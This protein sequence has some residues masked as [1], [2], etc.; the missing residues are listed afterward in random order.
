MKKIKKYKDIIAVFW[1][2]LIVSLI[3]NILIV[4][5]YLGDELW[6]FQNLYKI[7]SGYKLYIDANAITTPMF[8]YIGTIFFWI[9]GKNMI[10]FYI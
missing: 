5:D 9:L 8:Y 2:F 1:G 4:C 7:N 3:Y 10:A 6:L